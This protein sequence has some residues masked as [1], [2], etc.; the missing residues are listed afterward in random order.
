MLGSHNGQRKRGAMVD[1]VAGHHDMDLSATGHTRRRND[2]K[3]T[4]DV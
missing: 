3:D 4:L 1:A 2:C